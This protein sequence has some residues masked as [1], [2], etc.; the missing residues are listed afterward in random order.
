MGPRDGQRA[1]G[2]SSVIDDPAATYAPVPMRTGA[3]SC[4][5]VPMNAPSSMMV[6]CL[7]YAVVVAG[8]GAGADVDSLANRGVAEVRQVIGLRPLPRV[9]V[10]FSSTKLPT[11]RLLPHHRSGRRWANGPMRAPMVN[12][13]SRR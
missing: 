7:C 11:W 1:G 2:T 4:E 13:V 8:D 5:S 9:V 12:R 3:T 6:W 10:F